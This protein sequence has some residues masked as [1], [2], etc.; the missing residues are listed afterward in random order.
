MVIPHKTRQMGFVRGNTSIENY[1]SIQVKQY[2]SKPKNLRNLKT[3]TPKKKPK[4]RKKILK[5]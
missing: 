5:T 3:K 2:Y 4:S 1:Y